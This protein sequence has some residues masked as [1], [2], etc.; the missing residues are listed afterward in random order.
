MKDALTFREDRWSYNFYPSNTK[1]NNANPNEY[2]LAFPSY[3]GPDE[4]S[5]IYATG[6]GG[7]SW[8]KV[9]E[10]LIRLTSLTGIDKQGYIYAIDKDVK[11]CR[12]KRLFWEYDTV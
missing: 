11:L 3:I 8:H 2:Y 5:Y 6:D 7:E 1:W 9:Y 12:A 4:L 10:N